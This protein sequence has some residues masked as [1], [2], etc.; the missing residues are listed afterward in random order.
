MA[1]AGQRLLLDEFL[2][3]PEE[4]PALEYIDGMV[5]QKV[6]P[7][8]Q[9]STLQGVLIDRFNRFAGP[10]RL[11]Y[12]FGELRA[13]FGGRS[14]V[15][16]VS[17]YRWERI[18]RNSAGEVENRFVEPPDLAVEIVSPDQSVTALFRRCLWYVENDV[19]IALLVDPDDR[20]VIVFRGSDRPTACRGD[21]RLDLD[22]VLPGFQL[23]VRE[24]FGA[25]KLV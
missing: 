21:D 7:Q 1:I 6:S 17:L 25:L 12:A 9:H 19:R 4:E 3:L 16:D 22:E 20:S 18:P 5:I 14:P 24:L 15:P 8:G 2:R 10:R 23:T 11:A 13:T